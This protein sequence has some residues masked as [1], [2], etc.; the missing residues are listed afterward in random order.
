MCKRNFK[1]WLKTMRKSINQYNYYI[2]FPK[3]YKNVEEK[4]VEL[5]IL[6]ALVGSKNIKEEDRKSVV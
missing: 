4:K 5:H 3:V 2:D 1:D 6:N